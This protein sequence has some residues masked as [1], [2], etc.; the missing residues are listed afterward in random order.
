MSF[1]KSIKSPRYRHKEILSYAVEDEFIH[2]IIHDLN[3]F[4]YEVCFSL[5]GASGA[6]KPFVLST[7]KIDTPERQQQFI[8]G[9]WSI[10]E[11]GCMKAK[12]GLFALSSLEINA[13]YFFHELMHFYQDMNG[14]FLLPLQEQG[15]FPVM[16]DAKSDIIALMFCEAWA[17]VEAIRISWA[18]HEKGYNMG[19]GGAL[20]SLESRRLALSYDNYLQSG[21]DEKYAAANIFNLWYKGKNRVFYE[22][23]GIKIYNI[24]LARFKKNIKNISNKDMGE[25]FRKLEIPM[26]IARLP[27]G[28]IPNYFSQIDWRD[29]IYNNINSPSVMRRIKG[30]EDLYGK[31]DNINIQDIKCGTAPYIWNRLRSCEYI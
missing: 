20:R 14:L 5:F 19:W 31:I 16:L 4:G 15:K 7:E 11:T 6:Y 28:A 24:N 27:R 18:L 9:F 12:I 22:K 17:Q 8:D 2:S 1:V 26:L 21:L 29:E 13:Y 10:F 25:N 3:D 30:L 23:H